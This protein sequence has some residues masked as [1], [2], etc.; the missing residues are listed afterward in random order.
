MKYNDVHIR[1]I[2]QEMTQSSI[3]KIHLKI[4][5]LTFHSNFTGTNELKFIPWELVYRIPVNTVELQNIHIKINKYSLLMHGITIKSPGKF[6]L[7]EQYVFVGGNISFLVCY[8]V[9]QENQL[10]NAF[11]D[12]HFPCSCLLSDRYF[13]GW[14]F[15]MNLLA[16]GVSWSRN[17]RP[18]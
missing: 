14:Q 15:W 8:H 11:E 4:T 13:P 5:Y 9:V 6:L 17:L 16:R 10:Q 1:A 12:Y 2:S 3:A 18:C 7:N